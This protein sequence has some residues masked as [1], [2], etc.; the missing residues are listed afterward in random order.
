L[1]EQVAD[2]LRIVSPSPKDRIEP[3]LAV[4]LPDT[5]L[6]IELPASWTTRTVGSALDRA[7]VDAAPTG[8]DAPVWIQIRGA[9]CGRSATPL[10]RRRDAIDAAVAQRGF[11]VRGQP[12]PDQPRASTL[13]EHHRWREGRVLDVLG[14]GGSAYELRVWHV[15]LVS[16]EVDAVLVAAWHHDRRLGW[17]RGIRAL[18]IAIG[19]AAASPDSR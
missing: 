16:H 10:K 3:R 14:P 1:W 2:S 19:T 7:V 17:M 12:E 15:D 13:G 9:R 11:V 18:E 8:A 5:E 4:P 6:V